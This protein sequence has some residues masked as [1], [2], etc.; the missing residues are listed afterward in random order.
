MSGN[1]QDGPQANAI[2]FVRR[3]TMPMEKTTNM[4]ECTQ[5]EP[6]LVDSS[7]APVDSCQRTVLPRQHPRRESS[8]RKVMFKEV[9]FRVFDVTI[10]D[11][12]V[13]LGPA[14][15]LDWYFTQ[16]EALHVNDYEDNRAPRRSERELK[17]LP[18]ARADLLRSGFG[19]T[20]AD[21]ERSSRRRISVTRRGSTGRLSCNAPVER[22]SKSTSPVITHKR[23]AKRGSM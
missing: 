12:H 13:P 19:F 9:S 1:H 6:K 21:L 10:G 18:E 4:K 17:M 3:S 16:Q 5:N 7:D 15:A 2:E 14:L 23:M 20:D 22:Q 8:L 11:I